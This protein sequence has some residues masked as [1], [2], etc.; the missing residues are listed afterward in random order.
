MFDH[1]CGIIALSISFLDSNEYY[2]D[3]FCLCKLL[4]GVCLRYLNF[5]NEA[6]ECLQAVVDK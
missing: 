6:E 1:R 2:V 4:E 5:P 3:E